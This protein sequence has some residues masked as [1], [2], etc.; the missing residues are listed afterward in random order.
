MTKKIIT[1]VGRPN[2]GKST[3]FNR[4]SI[5][6][7]AIVHDLPGVTRDRKYTDGKIGSFEFL[8]IDTPGLDENPNS[9]GE[10]LM[11]QTT[12]AILEADLICFMVDG[13]SGI[14][15][16]DKLFSSFVRKYNKPVILVVNKCEKA[17]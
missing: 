1:L 5:R 8:L 14:L 15:P 7:K 16:D 3:L 12:K 6:K 2:V 13:R 4:L 9:M 17:F 11:E 10:R